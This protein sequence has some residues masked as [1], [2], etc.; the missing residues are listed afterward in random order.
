MAGFADLLSSSLHMDVVDDTHLDGL[1]N[2]QLD[3][4]PDETTGQ[5]SD[6]AEDKPSI[7][8]AVREQ[9]GLKLTSSKGP[10]KVW[11]IDHVELPSEN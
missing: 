3:W 8:T 10:V 6:E 9:L 5:A 1:Y 7:F 2:L 11:V 4:N